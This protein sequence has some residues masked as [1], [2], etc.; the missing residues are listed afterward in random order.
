MKSFGLKLSQLMKKNNMTDEQLAELLSVS[1]TTVLRWRNGERSP[2][3]SKISQI[4]K[5]L[6]VPATYF[7]DENESYCPEDHIITKREI[8]I[9]GT[10]A[11]GKPIEAIE[12]VI[13]DIQ[14]PDIILDKYGFEK[15]LALRINGDSMN[16]IV[17]DGHIAVLERTTNI[18]NGD[19]AAVLINGYDATLK[20]IYKTNNRIILEPD[21]FNPSIHPLM[22]DCTDIENCPEI[23]VVGKY[24]WSCAPIQ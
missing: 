8:P 14:V 19:I 16:R 9:Y 7:I 13:G 21:S 20:R 24:I 1:R 22:F 12:N 10:I 17:H 6:N 5:M 18:N 11:A 23:K 2:K 15:L 3:M 4:A